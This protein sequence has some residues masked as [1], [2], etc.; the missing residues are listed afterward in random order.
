MHWLRNWGFASGHPQ[1][2]QDS[3]LGRVDAGTVICRRVIVLA[4]KRGLCDRGG[5]TVFR[6]TIHPEFYLSQRRATTA[7]DTSRVLGVEGGDNPLANR[8]QNL[9]ATLS[10]FT[11]D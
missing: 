5:A 9:P 11:T 7:K 6:D 3:R 2:E 4:N 1:F 10:Y 8:E